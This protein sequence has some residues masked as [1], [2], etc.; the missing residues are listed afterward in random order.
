LNWHLEDGTALRIVQTTNYPWDGAVKLAI[1][2]AKPS[3]FS[4][5]LR[6]P[7]WAPSA[8]VL[9][10]GNPISGDSEPGAYITVTRTWQ[11]GDIVSLEFPEQPSWVRANPR[12]TAL[13][14]RAAVERGP[15]VFAL[16]QSDLPS[17]PISDVFLRAG[18]TVAVESRKDLFGTML[19]LKYPGFVADKPL[20]N[21]PLY[22]TWGS[23]PAAGRRAVQLVLLPY[24]SV[25]SRENESVKTWI[26]VIRAAEVLT[27][28]PSESLKKPSQ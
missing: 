21:Q 14:G 7:G 20:S 3:Q 15:L 17:S 24:F 6:W 1:S 27:A 5:H 26:P 19:L 22:S 12:A 25:G 2:P 8:R 18:G 10:N 13:Y 16:E 28:T 23:G 4:V 11:A 9:I